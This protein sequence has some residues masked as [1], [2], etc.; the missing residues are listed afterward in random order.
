MGLLQNV[1]N[2]FWETL[3]EF[4]G[5]PDRTKRKRKG[6]K[7]ELKKTQFRPKWMELRA[8][9]MP[10]TKRVPKKAKVRLKRDLKRLRRPAYVPVR[11]LK[12]PKVEQLEII[13]ERAIINKAEPDREPG[14]WDEKI[15][16]DDT[17]LNQAI[18]E[19][20]ER[21]ERITSERVQKKIKKNRRFY[22]S[23]ISKKRKHLL[24]MNP[25][26]EKILDAQKALMTGDY[27]PPW[28]QF[29]REQL[30]VLSKDDDEKMEVPA[31]VG[32]LLFEGLP[33]ATTEEKRAAVKREYFDPKGFSTILP[34]TEE[35]RKKFANISKKNVANILRSLETYQRNFG[36]RRPPRIMGRM[37]LKNPGIIAMDMFFP[38]MKIAG[39][40]GKYSC[41]T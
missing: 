9:R 26:T 5:G 17:G 2:A 7:R 15:E 4:Q 31:Q 30:S 13:R 3:D 12:I 22:D 27:L 10:E 29:F 16:D 36:R 11:A 8:R 37:S 34:I 32:K 35:L 14:G 18:E 25:G 19:P 38:T 24:F 21:V 41:L 33:M 40:A 6:L 28:A 23:T 1:V 20:Q 39:W